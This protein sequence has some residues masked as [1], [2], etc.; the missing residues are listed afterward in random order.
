MF[1]SYIPYTWADVSVLGPVRYLDIDEGWHTWNNTQA[2][3]CRNSTYIVEALFQQAR[4][5]P[6]LPRTKGDMVKTV[7]STC[8]NRISLISGWIWMFLGLLELWFSY[9]HGLIM[10][11]NLSL[12]TLIQT[13]AEASICQISWCRPESVDRGHYTCVRHGWNT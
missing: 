7:L 2:V 13:L 6:Y 3:G 9:V 12:S 1:W 4:E 8:F 11:D 5:H 10:S